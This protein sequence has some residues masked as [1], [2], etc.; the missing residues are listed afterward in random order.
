MLCT[1]WRVLSLRQ[2]RKQTNKGGRGQGGRRGLQNCCNGSR[3]VLLYDG[4]MGYTFPPIS[5]QWRK[6]NVG[7]IFKRARMQIQSGSQ[8]L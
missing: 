3:F 7:H 8:L 6:T 4:E 2:E 5:L 1:A